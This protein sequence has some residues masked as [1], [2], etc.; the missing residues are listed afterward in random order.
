MEYTR[1]NMFLL[2]FTNQPPFQDLWN[3][4]SGAE[5]AKNS[6]KIKNIRQNSRFRVNYA[7]LNQL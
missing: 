4:I 3:S 1:V 6:L 7:D 5:L 2:I